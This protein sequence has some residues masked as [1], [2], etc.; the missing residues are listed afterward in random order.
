MGPPKANAPWQANKLA[1]TKQKK[2][3]RLVAKNPVAQT[4]QRK[5]V[6]L[7]APK[8]AARLRAISRVLKAAQKL[9]VQRMRTSQ[10]ASR[11][12]KLKPNTPEGFV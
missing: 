10:P 3:V 1:R 4:K 8:N 6:A 2:S 9:A 5:S 7:I 12:N 11:N